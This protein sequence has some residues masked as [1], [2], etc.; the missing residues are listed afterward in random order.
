MSGN[1]EGESRDRAAI[2]D[3]LRATLEAAREE[4]TK[5][6]AEFDAL[7]WQVPSGIPS[8]DGTFRIEKAGKRRQ[9]AFANYIEALRRFAD[10]VLGAKTR[11]A[12][13]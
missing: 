1:L 8:P 13:G 11:S 3:A 2:E 5:V 4:Y 10:F 9:A 7:A 12:G 6:S